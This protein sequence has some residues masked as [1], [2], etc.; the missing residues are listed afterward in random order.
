MC[1]TT[2]AAAHYSS[3][4]MCVLTPSNI[5]CHE[6][7]TVPSPSAIHLSLSA[8]KYSLSVNPPLFT[9]DESHV[10]R[11]SSVG[12]SFAAQ[13]SQLVDLRF[14]TCARRERFEVGK[15]KHC[16]DFTL[17]PYRSSRVYLK[18]ETCITGKVYILRGVD[19]SYIP[20]SA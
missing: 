8:V 13:M 6:S 12:S 9:F 15:P 17:V 11:V 20:A 19:T 4:R 7:H 3:H 2:A 16:L 5:A 18:V 14:R 1:Q 10:P